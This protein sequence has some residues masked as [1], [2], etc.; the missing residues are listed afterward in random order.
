MTGDNNAEVKKGICE[1]IKFLLDD[2][3][4]Q[5]APRMDGILQVFAL[6]QQ[7]IRVVTF[8]IILI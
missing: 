7:H 1:T 2:H 4:D 5:L 3:M 8:I 6:K